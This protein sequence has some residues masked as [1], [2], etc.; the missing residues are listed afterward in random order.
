MKLT[1]HFNI[2]ALFVAGNVFF[3]TFTAV[4]QKTL[5]SLDAKGK[6]GDTHQFQKP[7]FEALWM[8]IF[9]AFVLAFHFGGKLIS[10]FKNG[11][12]SL[13][14]E[15]KT[16]LKTYFIIA[17][18][19]FCDLLASVTQGIG[20]LW[21]T[22]SVYQMLRG[23]LLFFGAVWSIIFLKRK[24]KSFQW[25]G[26]TFVIIALFM[27]GSASIFGD[28]SGNK[29][30][31]YLEL[32]GVLLIIVAQAIQAGQIVIEDFLMSNID[33]DPMVVVGFEGLWGTIM[34]LVFLVIVQFTPSSG[35]DFSHVYHEDSIDSIHMIGN[36]TAIQILVIVYGFAILGLN[37]CGMKVTQRT[38]AVVR[39]ITESVRTLGIWV[40]DLLA[41]YL[42]GHYYGHQYMLDH[43]SA[44]KWT[45][46]SFLQ[47]FGFMFM[48][49]GVF[50]YNQIV[51]FPFLT[52]PTEFVEIKEPIAE[53]YPVATENTP[54]I[55]DVGSGEK[56]K[57][58]V[59]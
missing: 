54:L 31:W 10:F 42:L 3:G 41:Y 38:Q 15:K 51:K 45:A 6:D 37:V 13:L 23:A 40:V 19:S 16:P 20:L 24:L 18:P 49:A 55:V 21:V 53:D 47:L 56:D 43:S 4:T 58:S 26:I 2:T 29:P 44:E 22:A 35:G 48:I 33:C 12:V 1:A 30:A 27:V 5:Y 14:M 8:F 46:W 59:Q 17:I 25:L 9:M 50:T 34:M 57:T 52:Y 36:S 7:Y 11:G 28:S 39:T 32:I